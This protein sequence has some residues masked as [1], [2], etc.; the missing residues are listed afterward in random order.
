VVGVNEKEPV[1]GSKAM[2]AM[3]PVAERMT[4]PP[5]PVGSLAE[6]VKLRI[7]PTVAFRGPGAMMIGR[8]F[9]VITVMTRL[10]SVDETSSVTVKVIV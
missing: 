4:V 3:S 1:A 7:V 2:L 6:I 10:A 5:E 8:T 9:V